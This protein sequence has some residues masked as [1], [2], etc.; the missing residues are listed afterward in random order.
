[1][2]A[3]QPAHGDMIDIDLMYIGDGSDNSLKVFAIKKDTITA[4]VTASFKGTVVKSQ[5]GLHGPR[6][7]VIAGGN[8]LVSD[9]NVLTSTNGDISLYDSTTGKLLNRVVPHDDPNA[10]AVPRGIITWNGPWRTDIFVADFTAETQPKQRPT[11]GRVRAYT[12]AGVFIG[13]LRP[14]TDDPKR[15]PLGRG[16]HPRAVVIGPDGLLYVTNFP[17]PATGLGGDVLRFDPGTGAFVDVFIS[18]PDGGNYLLN[19][20]GGICFGPDGNLYLISFQAAA[21]APT[22]GPDTD[23]V[24]IYQGP[25]G[26]KPG[27]FIDAID[28]DV[29]DGPRAWAQALVFGPGGQLFVPI[30]GTG[31][32]TGSVRSYNVTNNKKKKFTFDVFVPAAASGGPLG[33]GWFLTFGKTNPSTLIYEP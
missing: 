13:D 4:S 24:R 25:G 7:L 3:I 11:P 23:Q 22:T 30:T 29:A 20:P 26:N 2:A 33:Q 19:G 15:F 16:Y 1:M 17:N 28:L 10:A 31:P 6:G 14:P 27:A 5:A 18:E 32:D 21:D 12:A 8:L 9:Q